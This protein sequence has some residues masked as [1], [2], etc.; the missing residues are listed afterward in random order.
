MPMDGDKMRTLRQG[1]N[2]FTCL[3][4]DPGSPG[5]D[6]VCLDKNAMEWLMA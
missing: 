4:D 1:K 6:P 3:A 2:E 5:N